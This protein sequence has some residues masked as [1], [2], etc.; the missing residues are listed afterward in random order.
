MHKYRPDYVCHAGIKTCL[1]VVCSMGMKISL[2]LKRKIDINNRH[3]ILRTICFVFFL[4]N[5]Y[6]Q[7][8]KALCW[9]EDHVLLFYTY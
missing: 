5:P 2:K 3:P 4:K 9:C 6:Y 8:A 1:F 7:T